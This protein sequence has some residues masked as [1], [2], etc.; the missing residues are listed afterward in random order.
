[1]TPAELNLYLIGVFRPDTRALLERF[2]PPPG[3]RDPFEQDDEPARVLPPVLKKTRRGVP[4]NRRNRD[5]NVYRFRS[6]EGTVF[7]GTRTQFIARNPHVNPGQLHD[8]VHGKG[9]S[10]K[11]WLF[12]GRVEQPAA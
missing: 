10:A 3:G 9:R 12:L 4:A 2:P 5:K 1:M 11:G 7:I 6:P 8:L